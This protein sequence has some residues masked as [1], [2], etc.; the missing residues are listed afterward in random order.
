MVGMGGVGGFTSVKV[1]GFGGFLGW[2]GLVG[3][4]LGGFWFGLVCAINFG[5]SGANL[6]SF[7]LPSGEGG[8]GWSDTFLPGWRQANLMSG[9]DAFTVKAPTPP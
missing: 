4:L 1:M 7:L 6:Q 8:K 3:L 2:L 5:G 9:R